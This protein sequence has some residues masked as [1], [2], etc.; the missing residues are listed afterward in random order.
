MVKEVVE[1]TP[2]PMPKAVAPPFMK[3]KQAGAALKA[4]ENDTVAMVPVVA[5]PPT[6]VKVPRELLQEYPVA[7]TTEGTLVPTAKVATPAG[8][9]SDTRVP[10]LDTPP[11]A[12]KV[13]AKVAAEVAGAPPPVIVKSPVEPVHRVS[14]LL[15][16]LVEVVQ[17][18]LA[19]IS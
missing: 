13:P 18:A 6:I 2:L 5:V 16:E 12:F 15:T 4:A 9:E 7:Q 14:V 19:P 17:F 1:G 3:A 10:A 8:M 11:V